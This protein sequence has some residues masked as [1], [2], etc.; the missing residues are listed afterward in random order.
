MKKVKQPVTICKENMA[1]YKGKEGV[2]KI[3]YQNKVL[4]EFWTENV[5]ALYNTLKSLS[6][7]DT[8][9]YANL[10]QNFKAVFVE[11]KIGQ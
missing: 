8:G 6:K 9:T 4:K 1:E 10:P 7:R 5:Y 2:L 3:M 11:Q